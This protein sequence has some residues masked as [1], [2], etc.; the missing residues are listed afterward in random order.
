MEAHNSAIDQ[1]NHELDRLKELLRP[2]PPQAPPNTS[3]IISPEAKI[4]AKFRNMKNIRGFGPYVDACNEQARIHGLNFS[5]NYIRS[6]AAMLWSKEPSFIR[7]VYIT[8][9]RDASVVIRKHKT[10]F[11]SEAEHHKCSEICDNCH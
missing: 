9:A 7:D 10:Q 3:R 5:S 4:H 6:I 8:A 2:P 1:L 11:L